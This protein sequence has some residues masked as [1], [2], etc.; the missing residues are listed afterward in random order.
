[1]VKPHSLPGHEGAWLYKCLLHYQ[2]SQIQDSSFSDLR[3]SGISFSDLS[4]EVLV[5][6]VYS[7]V[8]VYV[9]HWLSVVD[10]LSLYF[11]Y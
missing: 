3:L 1:M 9:T 6:S 5:L 4:L 7:N 8:K 2:A 10:S 11:H